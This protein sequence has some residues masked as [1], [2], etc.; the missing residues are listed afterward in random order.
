MAQKK[1][2]V[3]GK[4]VSTA[5]SKV[6][7]LYLVVDHRSIVFVVKNT[8]TN[9]FVALEHFEISPD[10][11]GWNQLIGYLQNNSI[12]IHGIFEKIYF[13]MNG[14]R[15]LMT[16]VHEATDTLQYAHE[17]Q[18]IFGNKQDEEVYIS[19][20]DAQHNLVYGVP[21][22]LSSL[23]IRT[24]P[25]GKWEH[26]AHF[27]LQGKNPNKVQ[28]SIFETQMILLII[29]NGK[30]KLLNAYALGGNDQNIF[31]ILNACIQTGV[32]T[33]IVHLVVDAYQNNTS[34]FIN[35]LIPYF[36][37]S[38]INQIDNLGIASTIHKE[39]AQLSYAPYFIF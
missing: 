16:K 29:E 13:V 24:F 28:V 26:Y 3:Y 38:S 23:L 5:N 33:N 12:L 8:K 32:D 4:L 11:T 20:I 19:P 17:L 22:E 10:Q 39:H 30:T 7:N 31:T 14:P 27:L 37:S 9:E 1:F 18:F 15:M 2:S 34:D 21:D 25:T 36:M 6:E 35:T